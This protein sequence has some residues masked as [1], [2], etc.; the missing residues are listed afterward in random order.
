LQTVIPRKESYPA[1]IS[2]A[3][4][5]ILDQPT[6]ILKYWLHGLLGLLRGSIARRVVEEF[7]NFPLRILDT[8]RVA[9][10]MKG[11]GTAYPLP[12][13]PPYLPAVS[14]L[15]SCNECIQKLAAK[16]RWA[17]ALDKEMAALAWAE[18]F[19]LGSHSANTQTG[20]QSDPS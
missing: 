20:K 7:R 13:P 19:A 9:P 16:F 4:S 17:A 14:Y 15:I 1:S 10:T 5:G 11:L 3:R 6:P 2:G 8:V 12:L 18:G